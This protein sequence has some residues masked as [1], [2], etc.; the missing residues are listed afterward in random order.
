MGFVNSSSEWNRRSDKI[1]EGAPCVKQVDDIMGQGVDYAHLA[2]NP[3]D[4]HGVALHYA[5]KEEGRN[6]P[7]NSLLWVHCF[8]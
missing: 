7:S 3:R 4:K 8:F 5:L 6:W 1:L 2:A